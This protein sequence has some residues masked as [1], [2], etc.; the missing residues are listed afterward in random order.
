[1]HSTVR[2]AA[3]LARKAKVGRLITGHYSSRY[4]DLDVFL[5]EAR[6]IF[7]NTVLGLEG[8]TYEI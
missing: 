4:K 2:Q 7:P 1:M 8:T 6:P 3:Q 5:E